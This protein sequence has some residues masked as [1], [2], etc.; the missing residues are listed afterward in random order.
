MSLNRSLRSN[1]SLTGRVSPNPST[2]KLDQLNNSRSASPPPLALNSRS[3]STRLQDDGRSLAPTKPLNE[4]DMKFYRAAFERCAAPPDRR[5]IVNR[6]KFH[7][8]NSSL[9]LQDRQVTL[10]CSSSELCQLRSNTSENR[11][12]LVQLRTSVARF[13]PSW[14]TSLGHLFRRN[15]LR[16]LPTNSPRGETHRWTKSRGSIRHALQQRSKIQL[17]RHRLRS[18]SGRSHRGNKIVRHRRS[19]H[20]FSLSFTSERRSFYWRWISSY[21][22]TARYERRENRCEKSSCFSATDRRDEHLLERL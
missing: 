4:D 20:S 10:I 18:I 21:S 8:G 22:F 16:H 7:Q 2:A 9:Y 11:S 17:E 6:D 5:M 12:A 13:S 15:H 3:S 1:T 19:F 14:S